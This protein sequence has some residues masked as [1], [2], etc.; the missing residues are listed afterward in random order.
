M[1]QAALRVGSLFLAHHGNGLAAKAGE[2]GDDRVVLAETA[3]AGQRGEIREQPVD[4]VQAVR[5]VGMA[6]D[7]HLL[8][9][10]ERAV[11]I[12]QHIG[13]ALLHACDF[14]G[15]IDGAILVELFQLDDPAVQILKRLFEIEVIV[16][17]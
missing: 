1:L 2:A 14:V 3:V 7:L 4:V 17:A 11:E 16:H 10:R 8:P 6:R 9:G 5:P 13:R 15:E 12:A